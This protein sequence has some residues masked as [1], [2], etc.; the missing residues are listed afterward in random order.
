MSISTSKNSVYSVLGFAIPALVLFIAYPVLIVHLGEA[1][2]GLFI[3]ANSIGGALVFLEFGLSSAALKFLSEDVAKKDFKASADVVVTSLF[4]YGALGIAV[5]FTIWVLSPWLVDVLS[6]DEN[7]KDEAVFVIKITG[8][9]LAIALIGSVIISIYKG[10]HRFDFSTMTISLVSIATYGVSV[11]AVKFFDMGLNGVVIVFLI[12][13]LVV[14]ALFFFLALDVCKKAGI[15][16]RVGKMSRNTFNRMFSYGSAMAVSSI[17]SILHAQIQRVLIG[18]ILG[19]QYVAAYHVGVWAPSKVNSAT[20]S[21]SEPIF[22]K[23][24][25]L[26]HDRSA[27]KALY[28]RYLL[29]ITL[30][31][32]VSLLP[33][34]FFSEFIFSLWFNGNYP[35][36]TPSI[37]TIMAIALLLNSMGQPAHHFVN[38]I[39]K[40]WLNT[41]FSILSTLVLYVYIG[42]Q[43]YAN[44]NLDV[45]DFAWATSVS[46]GATSILYLVW[47][48]HYLLKWEKGENFLEVSH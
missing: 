41:Y 48:H 2:F 33:F 23:I 15:D 19:P 8:V 28:Y 9:Q 38:G 45:M 7:L 11:I 14:F 39:G 36:G 29:T 44:G 31:G 32:T 18:G 30:I 13:N 16:I 22:P 20:L 21:F 47:A 26:L 27:C 10:L 24:S 42:V 17:V 5:A 12:G 1:K 3:I 25:S 46:L 43:Y 34:L 37:A 4:F 40:P 6:I 35:A